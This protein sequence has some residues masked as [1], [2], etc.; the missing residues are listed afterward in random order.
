MSN[1][2][3]VGYK[4]PPRAT[5]F[6]PGVSGNPSGRPKR[7]PS[8]RET[9]LA[10]LAAPPSEDGSRQGNTNLQALVSTLVEAAIS[11]DARA[12]AL[13]LGAL[14]RFAEFDGQDAAVVSP[15]DEEILEAYAAPEER[16][17]IDG[18][19]VSTENGGDQITAGEA[20][21][22]APSGTETLK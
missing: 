13:V 7:C 10:K 3:P 17:A 19:P 20:A 12:Q 11:G 5:R 6:K 1:D 15:D 2:H 4:H 18:T 21:T 16:A 9:L 22:V 8:F 14:M